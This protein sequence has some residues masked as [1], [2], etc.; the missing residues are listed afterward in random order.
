M[1]FGGIKTL[2]PLHIELYRGLRALRSPTT[3]VSKPIGKLVAQWVGTLREPY[4]E[5]CATLTKTKT[6]LDFRRE[7]DKDF[8]DFLQRCLESPFSRK[9]D[10]WAYLG[11]TSIWML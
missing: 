4:V 2:S 8:R 7:S 10:L 5:Y 9:L 6:F 11:K 1:V 3:G